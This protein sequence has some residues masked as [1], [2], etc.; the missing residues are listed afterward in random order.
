VKIVA[1]STP[2]AV[3][4]LVAVLLLGMAVE[5]LHL[6]TPFDG[7]VWIDDV[8][9]NALLLGSAV[10]CV[11]RAVLRPGE[12]VAWALMGLSLALWT[13][14]DLYWTLV[15]ADLAE[16][17]YPSLADALWLAFLPT[18]YVALLLLMRNRSPQLDSRLW[19]DG[20]I[21]ALTAGAISAAVVFGAVQAST[22]GD[23]AAVATNLAYPL[24]DMIL[25]GT[26][27]GAVTAARGRLDRT[28]LFFAGG[29]GVFAVADSIYLFRVA[30][31]SYV[32]GG[33]LDLGWPV[34]ALLV[35]LAAW[36][37]P[38]RAKRAA[39]SGSRPRRSWPWSSACS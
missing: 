14:G 28:W 30:D 21:A 36:Q 35:G 19:L 4:V 26:V 31:G 23:T 7:G 13:G 29:I 5:T 32:A 33:L 12:R 17:P 27:L 37:P 10:L 2:V 18:A 11:A 3:R 38:V 39:V 1:T 20:I 15:L 25:I 8:L 9:Y 16:A 22:G 34:G 6:A 24:G